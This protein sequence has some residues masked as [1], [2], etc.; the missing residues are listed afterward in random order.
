MVV[1]IRVDVQQDQ[2]AVHRHAVHLA[3][4]PLHHLPDAQGLLTYSQE[5]LKEG[6]GKDQRVATPPLIDRLGDE[7]RLLEVG[8]YQLLD[9]LGRPGLVHGQQKD[10]LRPGRDLAQASLD[11][12][13]LALLVAGV[14]EDFEP[15]APFCCLEATGEAD[16]GGHLRSAVAQDH[17]NLAHATTG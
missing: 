11:G 10:P 6:G 1:L 13:G 8:G 7:G 17:D 14:D 2:R 5:L 15:R 9:D 4:M 3:L 16:I 12:G